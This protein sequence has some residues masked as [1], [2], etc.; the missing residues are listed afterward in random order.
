VVVAIVAHRYGWVP[1]DPVKNPGGKSI[2]WLECEHAWKK[3]QKEVLAFVVDP[4]YDKWPLD[5]Y[6]NYRLVKERSKPGIAEEVERN[7]K[8]LEEF[9]RELGKWIRGT[10]TDALGFRA[11][12]I[13]AL[14]GWKERHPAVSAVPIGDPDGYLK[15]LEEETRQI[16]IKG[17]TARR[18]EPYFFGIEEIYIPLKTLESREDARKGGVKAAEQRRIL[19]QRAL[20]KRNVVLIGEPGSGK[21]TFLRRVA[22]ELCRT[23]RETRRAEAEPFLAGD[24]RRFPLF[25]RIADLARTLRADE[26]DMPVYAPGWIPHFLGKQSEAYGWGLAKEFF[27]RKL[28]EGNCLVMVDGLDEAPGKLIRE[29]IARIFEQATRTFSRC[30]FL[31]S[32]RPQSYSGDSVLAGFHPLRIDDLGPEEIGFFC[33]HFAR[34]LALTDTE[35]EQFKDALQAA[36]DKRREIREMARNP[37]MLTALAV[38]QHNDQRVPEY[39]VE[40][41]GSILGWLAAARQDKEGRPNAEACLQTMRK[42]ALRM[43]DAPEGRLVQWNK[44]LAAEFL[45]K[46]LGGTADAVEEMLEQETQDSGIIA[47]AGSDL[48]FWH[49]SFQEYLAA[50]EIVGFDDQQIVEKVIASGKLYQPEWREVMRLL[51]GLLK[52]LGAPKIDWL[53]KAILAPLGGRP[54][55][56]EQARC[57]GL[58][59]AMMRDLEGMGYK[60]ETSEYERTIKA[61]ERIFDAGKAETIDFQTRLEAAEAL[62]LAGDPRLDKD[63]RVKIPA[64]ASTFWMGAQKTAKKG[65]NYD[66]EAYGDEKPV[67][68]VTLRPYWIGKYPVT[69]QEFSEFIQDGGYE[70]RKHWRDGGFGNFKEPFKWDRQARNSNC[71]VTGVSWYEAAAYCAW[72]GCRLPT[73]AEWERAA[74]GQAGGKYPWGN[75]PPLDESRANYGI[76]VGRVTPVGLYPKG[77]TSDGLCDMLGNVLEWCSDWYGPYEKRPQENPRGAKDGKYKVL[78]G[79]SWNDYPEFVRVSN[80]DRYEPTNR[81]DNFGFRC[82]GDLR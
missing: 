23:L 33:D 55:L 27:Q 44:R 76:K 4:N 7:E 36:L 64:E 25:I 14:A 54:K 32:T 41:Y 19:I 69:V 60:P 42:L 50:R 3:T 12:V 47:S 22:F 11:L 29:R 82:A 8:K 78:R 13:Q 39:R 34:A 61:V 45:M 20:K 21:S 74:R 28:Q 52:L 77:N 75:E 16:R 40:L 5:K 71:P 63:N 17:L 66:P 67:H 59:G 65:K 24:D 43:Q 31:V 72:K 15:W 81:D 38:L 58:L 79:G 70:Q 49:L 48:K 46:E 35:S 18:A 37:V 6:E 80:R 57:A 53:V 68:A 2:T 10:F 73:E 62:G 56:A 51:G 26:S 30:D 1:E 9:K